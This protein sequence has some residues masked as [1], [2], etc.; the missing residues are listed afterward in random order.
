MIRILGKIGDDSSLPDLRLNLASSNAAVR[1]AA[2]RALIDWPTAAPIEDV[3]DLAKSAE[4][5]THRL[6]AL[7]GFIR[8]TS[9]KKFRKPENA[10][11]DLR[12]ALEM[13][14]RPEEK[15]LALATLP[16]FACPEALKLAK[17][18]LNDAE[19]QAEAKAAV[20]KIEEKPKLT[21]LYIQRSTRPRTFRV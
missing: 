18:F 13:S 2:A 1:D 16:G 9:L 7:R 17:S 12:L 5:E 3:F 10:V 21:G 14:R 6:L 20:E 11:S 8:M 19:V 4:S 15:R